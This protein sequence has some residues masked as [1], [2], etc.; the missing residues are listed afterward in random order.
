MID[1]ET[2]MPTNGK[3]ETAPATYAGVIAVSA[4]VALIVIR[5]ILEH[6]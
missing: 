4:I 6:K 5:L 2:G 3:S 1:R